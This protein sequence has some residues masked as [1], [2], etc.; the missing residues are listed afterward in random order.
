MFLDGG[1]HI[2]LPSPDICP[3][4]GLLA[5]DEGGD[6]AAP[7]ALMDD[8]YIYAYD[9]SGWVQSMRRELFYLGL[10]RMY[11]PSTP[12]PGTALTQALL[13]VSLLSAF[14]LRK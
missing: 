14:Q 6:S 13:T 4:F 5:V 9:R 12:N 1:L 3:K 8:V 7:R 11:S 2:S 10:V